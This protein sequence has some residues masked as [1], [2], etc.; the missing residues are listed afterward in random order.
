M[1]SLGYN[2]TT[3]IKLLQTAQDFK[4]INQEKLINNND[5]CPNYGKKNRKQG[6]FASPFHAIFTDHK[7]EIQ[8]RTC[9]CGWR[10]PYTVEGL[11]GSAMHPDLLERQ[12]LFGR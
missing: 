10:S 12:S 3:Q 7:L 8:R 9:S 5:K 6:K 4:L 1:K 11:F 2:H